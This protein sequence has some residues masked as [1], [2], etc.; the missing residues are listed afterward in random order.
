MAAASD[1]YIEDFLYDLEADPHERQ[2]LVT[3]AAHAEIRKGLAVRLK[4]RMIQIGE[5][6]SIII[7]KQTFF[8]RVS[9][10][11]KR[12]KSKSVEKHVA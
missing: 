1:V 2:N 5:V 9:L 11:L 12:D 3:S 7:P 4:E 10:C 6:E 8:Q